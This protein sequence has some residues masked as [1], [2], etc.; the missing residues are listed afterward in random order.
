MNRVATILFLLVRTA[1][2]GLQA[3]AMTSVAAVATI[4]ITLVLVGSFALLVGNMRGML[5]RFGVELQVTAYLD[6]G[7]SSDDARQLAGRIVTV[8]GVSQVELVTP[9]AA[10]GRFER[11]AGAAALLEGLEENPLPSSL[12]ISLA[13]EHRTPEGLQRVEQ[14]LDG[15]P[16]VDELA[17]GQEWIEGYTRAVVLVRFIASGM[18]SVMAIAA[19][20]IVSNTIRLALYSRVDELEILALV[21]ASRTFVRVPFLLEGTL[22]GSAGGLLAVAVLYLAFEWFTP[23]IQFGLSFF[24]GNA[25]PQFFGA[26]ELVG[27]VGAGA[28]LGI[29]GSAVA[30]LGWRGSSS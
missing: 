29:L 17:R 6:P 8:E 26:F 20:M 25:Q 9:E 3:S 21:G 15:L 11:I 23:E 19:L 27:L 22:Q 16:G 4:A 10:L 2:R 14:A 1:F 18:G 24:L 5:E 7:L 13:E 28:S 12:E 30:L